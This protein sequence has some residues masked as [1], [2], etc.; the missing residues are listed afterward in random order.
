[1]CLGLL[2]S[3]QQ[4]GRR[5]PPLTGTVLPRGSALANMISQFTLA[6][7]LFHYIISGKLHEATW[8]GKDCH[9]SS[10]L[11]MGFVLG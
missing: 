8:G 4:D 2:Q 5:G 1:M 6:L 3:S 7:V 9:L 10:M 11:D